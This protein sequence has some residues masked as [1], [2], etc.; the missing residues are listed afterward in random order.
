MD[1]I[2]TRFSRSAVDLETTLGSGQWVVN[3]GRI[4]NKPKLFLNQRR[5]RKASSEN[6]FFC[7]GKEELQNERKA[8]G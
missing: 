7:C 2:Q 4:Q 1:N 6:I 3:S 5:E 8:S